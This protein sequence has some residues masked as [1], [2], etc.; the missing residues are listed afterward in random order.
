MKIAFYSVTRNKIEGTP[1]KRSINKIIRALPNEL[2][3]HFYKENNTEGL[4]KCYN[5][6]LKE[7]GKHFDYIVFVHD[8]V[9]IDDF[10]IHEKLETYHKDFDIVGLAGGINPKIQKLALWHI[11]CGGMGG[12]NLRGA[13]AHSFNDKQIFM[14][15]FGPTPSRVVLLDGLFLSINTK[16]INEVGFKFNE[17]YTF[18]HYDIASC[19]DA[20]KL[21][22]KLG[23]APIWVI[24][25]SPGLSNVNDEIFSKSQEQFLQEYGN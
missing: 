18:H 7:N 16:R 12:P 20:N 22:L 14:T 11:M 8:D 19:L 4:S 9:Y 1:F 6:F 25:K 24:H 13:V 23:V 3:M 5:T 21:K 17:N 2:I 10:N 15:S